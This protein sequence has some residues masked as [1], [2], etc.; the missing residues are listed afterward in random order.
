MGTTDINESRNIYK[1]ISNV[2]NE[3][4]QKHKYNEAIFE[5][6]DNMPL[7]AW[8]KNNDYT[9]LWLSKSYE[10]YFL[11]SQGIT[12]DD[13]IGKT[14]YDVYPKNIA[15]AYRTEDIKIMQQNKSRHVIEPVSIN[16]EVHNVHF[17]KFPIKHNNQ[18]YIGGIAYFEP[19]KID[20][21][22][23]NTLINHYE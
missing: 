17:F 5:M 13:Y 9:M 16:D 21:L 2:I 22:F 3:T 7:I 15:D 23:I 1:R 18:I 20:I 19:H 12:R 6:L 10:T 11:K 14:D 8:I 4:L